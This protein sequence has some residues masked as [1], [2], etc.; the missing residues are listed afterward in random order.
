MPVSRDF[1]RLRN[2]LEESLSE[3][4]VS[5][6]ESLDEPKYDE[7]IAKELDLKATVVRTILNELH[8]KR[9]VEYDRTKNKKTG[10]YTYL[11][12]KRDDQ[13]GEYTKGYLESRLAELNGQL[14]K[15]KNN[16]YFC[17]PNGVVT[18]EEA[19]ENNFTCPETGQPYVEYDNSETID[20]IINEI[21]RI[22]GLLHTHFSAKQ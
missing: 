11:W 21:S 12:K 16:A 20:G 15:E 3:Q 9:L 1:K 14:M 17:G 4:H 18:F 2:V 6:I 22:N 13:L 8:S 10:W 7:D 5:V 19:T